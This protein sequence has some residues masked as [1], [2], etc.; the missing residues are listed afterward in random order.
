M[1]WVKAKIAKL[2]GVIVGAVT[3]RPRRLLDEFA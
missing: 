2:F 3:N 1:V